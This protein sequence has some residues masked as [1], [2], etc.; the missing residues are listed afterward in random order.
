MEPTQA[1]TH[2]WPD[3]A[4]GADWA[5]AVTG[6]SGASRRRTSAMTKRMT[7]LLVGSRSVVALLAPPPSR[8]LAREVANRHEHHDQKGRVDDKGTG[9]LL[10]QEHQ[11]ADGQQREEG[12]QHEPALPRPRRPPSPAVALRGEPVPRFEGAHFTVTVYVATL[13][14]AT[15]C[16][17]GRRYSKRSCCWP[18][19]SGASFQISVPPAPAAPPALCPS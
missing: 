12:H 3:A 4:R 18:G 9:L 14:G 17:H 13:D 1:T 19:L 11:R 15:S 16:S 6:A 2:F 10:R 7:V 5:A 8:R